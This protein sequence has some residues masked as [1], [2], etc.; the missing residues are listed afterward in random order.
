MIGL[1]VIKGERSKPILNS[2]MLKNLTK[3]WSKRRKMTM[4]RILNRH[5]GI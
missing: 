1:S 2:N 3:S 5:T 4:Q